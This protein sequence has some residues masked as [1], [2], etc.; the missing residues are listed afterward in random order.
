MTY[1]G[2]PLSNPPRPLPAEGGGGAGGYLLFVEIPPQS[3]ANYAA[4]AMT[5]LTEFSAI[6][7]PVAS[8]EVELMKG[9]ELLE[10][11]PI[12]EGDRIIEVQLGHRLSAGETVTFHNRSDYT[13]W[14]V[15]EGAIAGVV[16]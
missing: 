12:V 3:S 13:L 10:T 16:P 6:S 5:V 7:D 9:A 1:F 8:G 14:I 15:L 2:Y 4:I 11:E